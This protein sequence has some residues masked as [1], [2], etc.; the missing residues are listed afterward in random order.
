MKEAYSIHT[1]QSTAMNGSDEN[2]LYRV[3]AKGNGSVIPIAENLT[4]EEATQLLSSLRGNVEE[5]VRRSNAGD[6]HLLPCPGC[7]GKRVAVVEVRDRALPA[8]FDFMQNDG[9]FVHCYECRMM[10]PFLE[11]GWDRLKARAEARRNWNRLPRK[12]TK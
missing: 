7:E 9:F 10:G 4:K 5:M 11:T 6:R 2:S 3:D 12:E 1:F 8:P